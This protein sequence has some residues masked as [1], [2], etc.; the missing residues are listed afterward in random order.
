MNI[1]DLLK[2]AES[3]NVVA[4]AILGTCYLDGID[5]DVDYQQAFRFLS[6]ASDLSYERK[7]IAVANFREG[8]DEGIACSRR[9]K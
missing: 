1:S 9:I 5:V 7:F 2:N 6:A 3:G 4:Q 8:H